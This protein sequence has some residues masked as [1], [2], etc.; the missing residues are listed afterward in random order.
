[1][2]ERKKDRGRKRERERAHLKT[3]PN[4]KETILTLVTDLL[5]TPTS[6]SWTVPWALLP[7]ALEIL[8]S[9]N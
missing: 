7:L 1:M 5:L 6:K 4:L 2:R 9:L 3:M 8:D